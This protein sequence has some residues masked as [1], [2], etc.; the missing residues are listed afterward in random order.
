MEDFFKYKFIL[1]KSHSKYTENYQTVC[2]VRFK[3]FAER[4]ILVLTTSANAV[5]ASNLISILFITGN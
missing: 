2:L 1:G 4:G 5:Q 3:P